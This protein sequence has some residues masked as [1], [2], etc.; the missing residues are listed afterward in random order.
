VAR[1]LEWSQA[2][3]VIDTNP[4]AE[5]HRHYGPRT[6]PIVR[7]L[8]S[9]DVEAALREL[10]PVPRFGS[11]LGK[12]MAEHVELMHS[13]GYG[14]DVNQGML[15][16][17][18]R[19]L[20]SRA[21][22]TDKPL[23]Q[24]I[25]VWAQNDP[26]PN[27]LCEAKRVGQLISKAMHRLDPAATIF[28][29]KYRDVPASSPGAEAALRVLRR[30]STTAPKGS[31]GAPISKGAAAAAQPLYHGGPCLRAGL[32]VG[33]IASLTLADVNLQDGTIEIRETKFFKDR[34]LPLAAGVIA[35]L[36]NYLVP[37]EQAGV[38]TSSGLVGW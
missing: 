27:R 12:V 38:A 19:F 5:L 11:F 3:G 33:E 2:L 23:N 32:R 14:Y 22:L 25:E 20:Q 18:D 9:D 24:L 34:L 26:S 6:T 15:L 10:R 17:F 13:L 7:A 37:C 4:F 16:R 28:P 1:F 21:E 29:M 30:G 8:V 35:A 31:A 36:K